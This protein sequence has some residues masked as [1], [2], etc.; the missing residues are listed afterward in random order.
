MGIN[1]RLMIIMA[2]NQHVRIQN[3]KKPTGSKKRDQDRSIDELKEVGGKLRML[4][5]QTAS[6]FFLKH[7][8]TIDCILTNESEY[9]LEVERRL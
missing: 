9:P 1:R 3:P 6:S 8:P 5:F 7:N 4:G 2:A